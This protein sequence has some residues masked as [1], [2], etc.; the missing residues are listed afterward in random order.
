MRNWL[1]NKISGWLKKRIPPAKEHRLSHQKIFIF[2]SRFGT[3]YL[4]LCALLFVLAT[5]YQNNLMRLLCTFLLALFLLHLFL[6]YINFASLYVKSIAPKPMFA[7]QAGLFQYL[8]SSKNPDKHKAQGIVYAS[9]WRDSTF[10]PVGK[11]LDQPT[12]KADIPLKFS[13]RGLH[14]LGRLTLRSDYP[15]GMFKCWTHLDFEHEVLVYP[16]PR[17]CKISLHSAPLSPGEK[18]R[19]NK[20]GYEEFH[21]LKPFQETDPLSNVAWKQMAKNNLWMVK[22][23]E[24]DS[25]SAN[26]L[27]FDSTSH[28]NTEQKLEELAFQIIELTK[29]NTTFGLMIP[30]VSIEPNKGDGHM[31]ACLKELAMYSNHLRSISTS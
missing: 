29:Q 19:T 16:R 4:V 23:F 2:P 9:W 3:W 22:T 31:H 30:G 21:S 28:Q 26:W 5:N 15:L 6:S 13:H 17:Q 14:K 11:V 1:A 10:D 8:I 18:G 12:S 7:E 25:D 27:S 24:Q 20:Q